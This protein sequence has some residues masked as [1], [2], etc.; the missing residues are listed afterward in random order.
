ML[1]LAPHLS[2][3]HSLQ[4]WAAGDTAPIPRWL[5]PM[6]SVGIVA[7]LLCCCLLG[8][9]QALVSLRWLL[10]SLCSVGF[11]Y[12]LLIAAH[13]GWGSHGSVLPLMA[14]QQR[15]D[16][17]GTTQPHTFVLCKPHVFA[18]SVAN[19]AALPILTPNFIPCRSALPAVLGAPKQDSVIL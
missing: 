17:D 6:G 15:G 7:A 14:F 16:T 5:R 3:P 2:S 10:H 1:H 4:H 19:A 11:D 13:A 9:A 12:V 8:S 18:H